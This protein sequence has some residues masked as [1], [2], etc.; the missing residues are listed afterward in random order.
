M[1]TVTR[2]PTATTVG[3]GFASEI[4]RL[5]VQYFARYVPAGVDR[6]DWLAETSGVRRALRDE[7][8]ELYRESR[9]DAKRVAWLI[10]YL[11]SDVKRR[12][13]AGLLWE[14]RNQLRLPVSVMALFFLGATAFVVG[15]VRVVWVAAPARPFSVAG[16]TVVGLAVGWLAAR[17]WLSILVERRRFAVEQA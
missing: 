13:Q 9:I 16:V 2:R 4:D 5:F 6:K 12:W 10:R 3:D 11:I 1:A 15:V 14:Y 7:I 8:T 17:D